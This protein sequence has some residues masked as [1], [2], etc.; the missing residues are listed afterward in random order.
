MF[1]L[2]LNEAI[3]VHFNIVFQQA[4]CIGFLLWL[5]KITTN[6]WKV[7]TGTGY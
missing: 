5:L 3:E 1:E 6:D 4:R 2:Y 7:W